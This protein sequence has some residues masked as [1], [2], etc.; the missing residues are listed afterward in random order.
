MGFSEAIEAGQAFLK[1]LVDD[2]DVAKGFERLQSKLDTVGKSFTKFGAITGGIG[3]AITGSLGIA[4]K[5]FAGAGAAIDDMTKRTGF[6]AKALGELSY[7]AQQSGTDIAGVE[8]AIKG[9]EKFMLGAQQGGASV[10]TTLEALGLSLAD[11]EGQ[12][13][14]RQFQVLSEAVAGVEDPTTRAAL[15]MKVFGKSGADLLPLLVEGSEGI[16]ALRAEAQRLGVVMT[17]EDVAAAAA[18][19]D[20]LSQL[21]M[22]FGAVVNAIGAA[23]AGPLLEYKDSINAAVRLIIDFINENRT[24]VTVIGTV[25]IALVGLGAGLTAIGTASILAAKGVGVL[26]IALIAM[27]THPYVAAIAAIAAAILLIVN[28]LND[29]PDAADEAVAA[30]DKVK[31]PGSTTPIVASAGSGGS[32]VPHVATPSMDQDFKIQQHTSAMGIFG[33]Y[34]ESKGKFPDMPLS[35]GG[36][37]PHV[38]MPGVDH[39]QQALMGRL[40]YTPNDKTKLDVIADGWNDIVKKAQS[41]KIKLKL[42]WENWEENV[43]KWGGDVAG[44]FLPGGEAIANS[45]TS[46]GTFSATAAAFMGTPGRDPQ[47]ELLAVNKAQLEE[48]R[49]A[50]RKKLELPRAT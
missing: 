14:E 16:A 6:S 5:Q 30:L 24:L 15:A 46:L 23:V 28:Y 2:K 32:S 38:A 22:Q 39:E 43:K 45:L 37:V 9:M 44:L 7:A 25:G 40:R 20:A 17:E 21:S 1:I 42:E 34:E 36:S 3:A 12:T 47:S 29:I 49:I 27:S 13:P 33:D 50:N 31:P 8:K 10:V 26:R 4:V 35:T 19:D 18:F 11:L 41:T 48:Q